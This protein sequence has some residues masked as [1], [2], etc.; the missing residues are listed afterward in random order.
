MHE[1]LRAGTSTAQV[2]QYGRLCS[3][4]NVAALEEHSDRTHHRDIPV[5]WRATI[6]PH[7]Y[8]KMCKTSYCNVRNDTD[9][10]LLQFFYSPCH[11]NYTT[12]R[13]KHGL[14]LPNRSL[15]C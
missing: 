14:M 4:F 1:I 15:N 13:L 9:S 8:D 10:H 3:T 2:A 11:Q 6:G 7:Q 12:Y 5:T